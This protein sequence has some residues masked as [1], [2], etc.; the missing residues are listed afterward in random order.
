MKKNTR[1]CSPSLTARYQGFTLVELIIV[2]AILGILAAIAI[3]AYRSYI[4][5][6]KQSAARSVL[7]QVPILI[8]TYRAETGRMCP[9]CNTN[10]THTYSYT[11]T[12]AGIEDTAGDRITT[13]FPDFKAK[14]LT[15]GPS[16]YHYQVVFTV[17]GC[18]AACSE[19]AVATALPQ[20]ARDAPPG[21]I[22][23]AAYQ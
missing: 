12:A 20:A 14:G 5:T 16:L 23:G 6:G 18:P 7:E 3:P 8:E 15:G 17:A 22:V 9:L 2:V 21:N 10:G 11:E 19:S 4:T 13:I 1:Y